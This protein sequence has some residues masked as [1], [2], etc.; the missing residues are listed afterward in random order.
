LGIA[1]INAIKDVDQ[2]ALWQSQ[3]VIVARG[4]ESLHPD[5]FEA[6]RRCRRRQ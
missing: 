5:C 3:D 1:W 6:F 4:K 2:R